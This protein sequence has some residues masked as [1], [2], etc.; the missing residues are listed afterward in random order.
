MTEAQK[1]KEA[2]LIAEDDL[3]SRM[4]MEGFISKMG[5]E[6]I[7][8]ED[9]KQAWEI[10][11]KPDAPALALLDWEMPEMDGLEVVSRV[12]EKLQHRFFYLIMVTGKS[13]RDEIIEGI[14]MGADDYVVKP[15]DSK[16]LGV[17][18]RAGLRIVELQR[19]LVKANIKLNELARTD[20]LTGFYNRVV[21]YQDLGKRFENRQYSP[22]SV[23]FCMV[24][25]DNFKHVN[26]DYGHDAGDAVLKQFAERIKGLLRQGDIVCRMG[27]EE[28]LLIAPETD[29]SKGKMVAERVRKIIAET[30]FLLPSGE[31]IP[32]TCSLGVHTSLVKDS[33]SSFDS[34]IKKADKALY[35]SK[36]DGRNRVTVFVPES[37]GGF[38]GG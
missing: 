19:E 2:I 20:G 15:F 26:D 12:R 29:E 8:A 11:Q 33:K 13:T 1:Q 25:I 4:V 14:S 5:Y 10:L 24:D 34:Q 28:F 18:I 36:A 7:S 9:G 16:E 31:M 6:P 37:Q 38:N 21:L 17:R 32:V 30:P 22:V 27:G 23:S 3:T 35:K